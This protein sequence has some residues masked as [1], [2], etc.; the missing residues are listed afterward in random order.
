MREIILT[1]S[2]FSGIL[3]FSM[4]TMLGV[5]IGEG[6][7]NDSNVY[8]LISSIVFT[9]TFLYFLRL[10]FNNA[11]IK[12]IRT[13]LYTI[14][15]LAIIVMFGV[16]EGYSSSRMFYLFGIFSIPAA[17]TGLYYSRTHSILNM[18]RFL[19]I[20]MLIIS[21]G[22]LFGISTLVQAIY[23]GDNNYSQA[24]SYYMALA[25]SLNL[26]LLRYGNYIKRFRI[27]NTCF[28]KYFCV[29][30]FIPQVV[31][32]LL[33]GGK[34][35]FVALFVNLLVFCYLEKNKKKLLIY[36]MYIILGI[37]VLSLI[38]SSTSDV[39]Q[40][41]FEQGFNR[42]FSYIS[43]DG[44]DMS[45][46]S[47]RDIVYQVSLE[48]FQNNPIGYGFFGYSDKLMDI[49]ALAYPH[50]IFLEWLLQGGILLFLI[51][52]VILVKSILKM[53]RM[54]KINP[55]HIFLIPITVQVLVMLQFS[56]S[57][58]QL[59]LFWFCC[60]YIMTYHDNK[61]YVSI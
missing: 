53:F 46:T 38:L 39:F 12:L 13:E 5:P 36:I 44:I 21:V 49:T 11:T 3:F 9:F 30:L 56:F 37:I 43:K 17:L 27:F 47:G 29:F 42:V 35:G 52:S 14:I 61:C 10:C 59:S 33:S 60:T 20:V 4:S 19:D 8:L 28:Y 25:F 7:T 6:G 26:F 32:L 57:Y 2:I 40:S 58:L 41:V 31:F 1:Y 23:S 18:F 51:C 15:I 34:G 16:I 48:L 50:N 54:V 45:Q 22:N 24:L 55:Y